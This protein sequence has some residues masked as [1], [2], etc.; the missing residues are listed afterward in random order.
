MAFPV[1]QTHIDYRLVTRS[2]L[3]IRVLTDFHLLWLLF[4]FFNINNFFFLGGWV[5][6]GDEGDEEGRLSYTV[7][8][9]Y[10]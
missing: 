10:T 8:I 9:E 4:S 3:M 6:W 2:G 7:S 1:E 5:G